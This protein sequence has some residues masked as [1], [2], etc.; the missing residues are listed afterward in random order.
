M[1][2]SNF[3]KL[4]PK[5]EKI[6]SKTLRNWQFYLFRVMKKSCEPGKYKSLNLKKSSRGKRNTIWL[7]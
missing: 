4:L 5:A 7:E 1:K 2:L 3:A 6:E